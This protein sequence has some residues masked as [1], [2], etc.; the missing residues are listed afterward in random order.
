MYFGDIHNKELTYTFGLNK[1]M[2]VFYDKKSIERNNR[3]KA[4]D[5]VRSAFRSNNCRKL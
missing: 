3:D 5:K 4:N 2:T 1:E